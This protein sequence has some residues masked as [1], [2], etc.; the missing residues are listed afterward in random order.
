MDNRDEATIAAD[1]RVEGFRCAAARHLSFSRAAEELNLTQSAVSRQISELE[2]FLGVALFQRA[3]RRVDL[4]EAGKEY[5]FTIVHILSELDRATSRVTRSRR[6]K[7]ITLDILPTVATMWLMP[8]LEQLT[9]S[10]RKVDLR[11]ITSIQPVD[12]DS[13]RADIAVRVGRLPGR[14][15]LENSPRI[16]L[17]M[18]SKWDEVVADE[19]FPDILV[20]VYNP[21]L[22]SAGPPLSLI[23][24]ITAYPLIHTSSRRYAWPDW[25]K[26]HGIAV[27][28]PTQDP[29]EFGHFFMSLEA[30][31]KGHGIAIIPQIILAHYE[32]RE[33]L[34]ALKFPSLPSAGEYYLLTPQSAADDPDVQ[35]VREA[36][37]T[38]AERVRPLSYF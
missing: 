26:A 20:P 35:A 3:T 21:A 38:E 32:H 13:G 10:H 12:F 36:I 2:D 31:R 9:F 25:L 30:A 23:E 16:E 19:L 33:E 22:V 4:T 37:K 8:R 6:S 7:A 34:Q 18:V 15:Y 29:L 24:N 5:F 1:E 27:S 17:E 14:S 11:L 28:L